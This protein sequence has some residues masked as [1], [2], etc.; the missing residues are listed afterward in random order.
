MKNDLTEMTI[1]GHIVVL[2]VIHQLFSHSLTSDFILKSLFR[3]LYIY[4]KLLG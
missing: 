3:I 4:I 1:T 2:A